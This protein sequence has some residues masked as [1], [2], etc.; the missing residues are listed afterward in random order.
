M[1]YD[2]DA[3]IVALAARASTQV[4]EGLAALQGGRVLEA[5]VHFR[6]AHATLSSLALLLEKPQPPL[7]KLALV[8][9]V[10]ESTGDELEVW[11]ERKHGEP[12][13]GA[14]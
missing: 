9:A 11:M 10:R 2:H 12:G 14:A 6:A 5:E 1:T 8:S 4:R 7:R 3:V 13:D